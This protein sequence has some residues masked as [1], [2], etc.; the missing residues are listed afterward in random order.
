MKHSRA[1][2]IWWLLDCADTEQFQ[3]HGKFQWTAQLQRTEDI[4]KHFN[5]FH[6]DPVSQIQLPGNSATRRSEKDLISLFFFFLDA[7]LHIL[8]KINLPQEVANNVLLGE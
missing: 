8:N 1:T 5:F 4:L 2:C 6:S 7:N 3:H